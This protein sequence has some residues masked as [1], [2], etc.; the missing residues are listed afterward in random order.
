MILY[1]STWKNK[2]SGKILEKEIDFLFFI[3]VLNH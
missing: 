3:F 2:F 1:T